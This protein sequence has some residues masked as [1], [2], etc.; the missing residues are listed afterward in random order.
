MLKL[1]LEFCF[2]TLPYPLLVQNKTVV[3]KEQGH[4]FRSCS[5]FNTDLSCTKGGGY[6][7]QETAIHPDHK[8]IEFSRKERVPI[9]SRLLP[10]IVWEQEVNSKKSEKK[11][12]LTKTDLLSKCIPK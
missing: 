6:R 11:I 7:T 5:L 9:E 12:I 1:F 8:K 4:E 2:A 3:N 10:K